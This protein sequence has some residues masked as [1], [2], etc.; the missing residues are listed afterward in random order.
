MCCSTNLLAETHAA[1]SKV[2]VKFEHHWNIFYAVSLLLKVWYK[3]TVSENSAWCLIC[4]PFL[5]SFDYV[6]EQI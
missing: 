6:D 1:A 2:L 5:S 4:A 3:L